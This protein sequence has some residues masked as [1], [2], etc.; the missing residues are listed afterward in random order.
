MKQKEC[1]GVM[2]AFLILG[3]FSIIGNWNGF[4]ETKCLL[5]DCKIGLAFRDLCIWLLMG[6]VLIGIVSLFNEFKRNKE[7]DKEN[8]D[9][10]NNTKQDS[11]SEIKQVIKNNKSLLLEKLEEIENEKDRN[12]TDIEKSIKRH[13]K[14]KK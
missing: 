3:I 7:I 13:N 11:L 1:L 10:I 8:I 9:K 4:Y 5:S 14:N 2:S 6:L 12:M